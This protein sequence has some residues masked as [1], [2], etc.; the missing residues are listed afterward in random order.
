M[1]E[2]VWRIQAG[3]LFWDTQRWREA[4]ATQ[5]WFSVT[6][7]PCV[8]SKVEG[9]AW[10]CCARHREELGPALQKVLEVRVPSC[11]KFRSQGLE[12]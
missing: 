10:S 3:P 6:G 12:K 11:L 7:A 8:G 2:S 1:A 9:T 4:E 5:H